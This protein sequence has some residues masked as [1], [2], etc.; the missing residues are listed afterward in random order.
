ML[1]YR[2]KQ[3]YDIFK[4]DIFRVVRTRQ[5]KPS[6][7]AA[8]VEYTCL[9]SMQSNNGFFKAKDD[10]G[11]GP[12][13]LNTVEDDLEIIS[14]ANPRNERLAKNRPMKLMI[15]E[16]SDRFINDPSNK[17]SVKTIETAVKMINKVLDYTGDYLL[18]KLDKNSNTYW[19]LKEYIDDRGDLDFDAIM[20]D[21]TDDFEAGGDWDI[22]PYL[23]NVLTQVLGID[24][25]KA[26][27]ILKYK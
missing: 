27:R 1:T 4:G 20:V 19:Q 5:G 17:E 11:I 23:F 14:R 6:S 9:D 2:G 22:R 3:V 26:N 8:D 7:E 16:S 15:R 24:S 21:W 25:T 18:D 13:I 10:S 12:Y